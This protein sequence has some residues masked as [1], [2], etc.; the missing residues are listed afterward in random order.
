MDFITALR[1]REQPSMV[2]ELRKAL[3]EFA[4]KYPAEAA[5][6]KEIRMH[7]L[8]IQQTAD[9]LKAAELA[10][11]KQGYTDPDTIENLRTV[12]VLSAAIT[13]NK[14]IVVSES[15]SFY[16]PIF[17][18]DPMT[19]WKYLRT[20]DL[21]SLNSCYAELNRVHSNFLQLEITTESAL[22]IAKD[23]QNNPTETYLDLTRLDR[24]ALVEL[25]ARLSSLIPIK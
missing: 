10:A 2:F 1:N 7:L 4:K 21:A 14:K 16:E 3:P 8:T 18:D 19:L 13:S 11:N 12:Y 6:L 9:A 25:A 23:F 5:A 17:K 22:G 24:A 20:D 15:K